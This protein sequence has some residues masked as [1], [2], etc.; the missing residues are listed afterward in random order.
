[1]HKDDNDNNN[2]NNDY[3]KDENDHNLGSAKY[4]NSEKKRLIIV[5]SFNNDD[6]FSLLQGL[7]RPQIM[8][9]SSLFFLLFDILIITD[10][11]L[12]YVCVLS[13]SAT[14]KN[15]SFCHLPPVRSGVFVED[16]TTGT[17]TTTVCVLYFWWSKDRRFTRWEREVFL[18]FTWKI[19]VLVGRREM[20]CWNLYWIQ[21]KSVALP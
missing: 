14:M 11:Y 10:F 20:L 17:S 7:G 4:C 9:R 2:K 13:K 1:M 15:D 3:K 21:V 16:S 6:H 8:V 18:V 5:P 12:I 19:D